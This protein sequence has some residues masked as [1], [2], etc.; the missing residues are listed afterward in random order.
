MLTLS[1][2]R[3]DRPARSRP[4]R[5]LLKA[6][7]NA[8]VAARA[9]VFVALGVIALSLSTP[10][11]ANAIF[12]T[13]DWTSDS[14]NQKADMPGAA[15]NIFPSVQQWSGKREL[16]S[17]AVRLP[18]DPGDY[19]VYE[20]GAMR[21][22]NWASTQQSQDQAK[23]GERG[24]NADD[25]DCSVQNEIYNSIAQMVFDLSKFITRAS[26][27]IKEISS[28]PSPLAALYEGTVEGDNSVVDRLNDNVFKLAVPTMIML[29]GIWVFGKWRKG[30]M[31]EVW[32][33]VG[34]AAFVVIAVSAFLVDN[35]YTRV[36][37][38]ADS[39]IAQGNAALTEAVLGGA[40]DDIDPPCDLA[41]NAPQRGMRI[42]SCAMYDTLAFRPWAIGQFG[43]PG[44]KRMEYKG[45]DTCDF[46]D[47][48][49]CTDL[50]AK[51]VNVQSV[52]NFDYYKDWSG[53]DGGVMKH[54]ENQYGEL[55]NYIAKNEK[56]RVYEQWSG[57]KPGNRITMG[58][59]ALIA[60]LIVGIMVV[61]LSA[62]TLLWHSVTLIMIIL[63]PLVAIISI[64][65][66]QQKLLRGWWQTFVHSFVLRAGFGVIL[67]ILLLFYQLILPLSVPL[68]MQL[69]MLLLVTISV[70]MLLKNLLSG[71]FSPQVAGAEDALGVGDAA[72]AT[73]NKAAAVA[74]GLAVSTARTTGRVA[75][76]TAKGVG[77]TAGSTARG[78][79]WAVDKVFAKG[80]YRDK[81]QQRGWLG[82]S[83]REQRK[84]AYLARAD[85]R[86]LRESRA[87]DSGDGAQP[88]PE[89]QTSTAPRRSGRVSGSSGTQTTTQPTPTPTPTPT[90]APAP[91]PAATPPA[92][93]PR[94][95]PTPPRPTP[96][97]PTPPAAPTPPPRDP[98]GPSGR[99]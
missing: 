39:G 21:G 84:D 59:Y 20:L 4:R 71:K 34:W 94:P 87:R 80:K 95:Q 14:I 9:A 10:Q 82:Q 15:E 55:R 86:D 30:D 61:V 23:E 51:Q 98:R 60:S 11:S 69:L 7:I 83:K 48:A 32:A 38:T 18:G 52:T 1:R 26:I 65:P 88:E 3:A 53:V 43:D 99:V 67:T 76:S 42:S 81:M 96:A 89:G 58:I 19:T 40:V 44:K 47:K 74:P 64:H 70:V 79:A 62:L 33:G 63:L 90:P 41:A 54:K 73:F 8:G 16:V 49:R 72:N 46:G 78:G 85:A 12:D 28:N 25:D 27:S 97:D 92:P 68:G 57:H 29:T 56:S 31:R 13:C 35:N 5:S 2:P 45:S 37:E 75:G 24:E 50:R 17:G 93:A 22:L 6:L 91:A 77:R 66:T 36:V